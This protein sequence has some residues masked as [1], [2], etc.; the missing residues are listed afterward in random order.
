MS[1]EDCLSRRQFLARSTLAAAG[2]AALAACGDGQFG[3]V[4]VSSTNSGPLTI[5]VADYPGLAS[6]GTLVRI[7]PAS[8]LIAVKRTGTSSFTALSVVCTHEGCESSLSG[9]GFVCFCHG[10]QFDN[11][12]HVTQGPASSNLPSFATAYNASTDVLTIG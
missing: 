10:S 2:A 12:G 1:C 3:P 5:K 11:N 7:S 9:T 4:A 6:T 8:A